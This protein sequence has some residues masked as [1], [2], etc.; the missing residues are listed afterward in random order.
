MNRRP[1]IT[2]IAV[3]CLVL[4]GTITGRM[5]LFYISVPTTNTSVTHFD[6]LI[7]LGNPCNDD[8]TPGP[9]QRERVLESVREYKSGIAPHIIMSGGA[10]HNKY[11]EATSM[12]RLAISQGVPTGAVLED[13]Q[14]QNTI[15]NM[16]YSHQIMTAQNWH[17]AE[18]VSS[19]SHLPRAALI[20]AKYTFA[21]RTHP[22]HWPHEYNFAE[23][24]AIYA[25]E[26]KD[27][28]Q[29]HRTGFKPGALFPPQEESVEH[30][31]LQSTAP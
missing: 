11:V 26:I 1:L 28:W 24:L 3:L 14:A 4:A 21:W 15:Q 2:F 18:V 10:A 12:K 9:E 6:T 27:C 16:Y 13:D 25:S 8:G 22:A 17:S 23:I 20:L 7:V 29:I 5:A 30:P 31:S 19:P